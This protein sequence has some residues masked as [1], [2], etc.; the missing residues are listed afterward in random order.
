ML[1]KLACIIFLFWVYEQ[2]T[3]KVIKSNPKNPNIK[4]N[5]H[6]PIIKSINLLSI[7]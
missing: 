4:T 6:K 5:S 7:K 2:I 3:F 1:A